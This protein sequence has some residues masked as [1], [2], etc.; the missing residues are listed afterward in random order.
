ME[1]NNE[2]EKRKTIDWFP[3]LISAIVVALITSVINYIIWK[4]QFNLANES[5]V[6]DKKVEMLEKNKLYANSI[7]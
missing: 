2:N 3:P 1:T 5:K 6:Y 4:N 7:S